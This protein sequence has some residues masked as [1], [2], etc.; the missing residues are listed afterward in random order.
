[1]IL[2]D[3]SG[4]RKSAGARSQRCQ[5]VRCYDSV[6]YLIDL[7]L[8]ASSVQEKSVHFFES[9]QFS[10]FLKDKHIENSLILIKGSRYG[11]ERTLDILWRLLH[12]ENPFI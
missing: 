7:N 12:L 6:C 9:W 10:K 1:M 8:Y 4:I 2:G 3:A 5:I 11:F